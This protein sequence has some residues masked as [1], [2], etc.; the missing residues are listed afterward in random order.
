ME[1]IWKGIKDFE[2]Y[3]EV[4][5]YGNIRS[6]DRL[7]HAEYL[8]N[9]PIVHFKGQKIKARLNK[10]GYYIVTL[11]K[12]GNQKTFSVHRLVALHFVDNPLNKK[13]VDHIN[14]NR[15]DN[16]SFNLRWVSIRENQN[17]PITKINL[18]NAKVGEKHPQ[19]GKKQSKEYVEKRVSKL[20][21]SN[22]CKPVLQ[23]DIHGN[24]VKE[25]VSLSHV[26]RDF[27]HSPW[28]AIKSG[29]VFKNYIWKYK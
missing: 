22:C 1:E 6:I 11:K 5:N 28:D 24:V 15:I 13:C 10:D 29:K 12:L 25:Y 8:K 14:A 3:Y 27:G 23:L 26:K 9:S 16:R 4:S 18:R 17:N 21:N 19:Y 2:G 20:R 7:Y